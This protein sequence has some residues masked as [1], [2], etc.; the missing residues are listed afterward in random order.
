MK[1]H[2]E[3]QSHRSKFI[4][5]RLSLNSMASVPEFTSFESIFLK[6]QIVLPWLNFAS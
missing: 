6:Q 5:L 2:E 1:T 4:L 3:L